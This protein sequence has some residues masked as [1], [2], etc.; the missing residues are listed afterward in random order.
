MQSQKV[1]VC[2][3]CGVEIDRS[4]VGLFTIGRQMFCSWCWC[5]DCCRISRDAAAGGDVEMSKEQQQN[6]DIK[7][8]QTR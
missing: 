4:D 7:K 2:D 5:N 3:A 6:K 1:D 8:S